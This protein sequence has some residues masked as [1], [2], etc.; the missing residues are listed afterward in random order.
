MHDIALVN[1]AFNGEFVLLSI[2][3]E[4]INVVEDVLNDGK[5]GVGG[6][7]QTGSGEDVRNSLKETT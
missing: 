7:E 1:A 5:V 3:L 4:F 6:E 2:A